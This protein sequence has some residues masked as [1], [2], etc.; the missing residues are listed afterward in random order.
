MNQVEI[1]QTKDK[2]T[3]IEVKFIEE[4]VWLTKNQ[5]TEHLDRDRP[6]IAPHISNILKRAN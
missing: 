5:I 6:F 3:Q 1:Y 4:T 2:R